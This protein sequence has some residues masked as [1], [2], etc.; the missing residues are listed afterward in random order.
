MKK[1]AYSIEKTKAWRINNEKC[2]YLIEVGQ[3]ISLM[4][5][6]GLVIRGTV[7]DC[8]TNHIEIV[9]N[10]IRDI[11]IEDVQDIQF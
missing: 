2:S 1:N 11:V 4:L 10:G 8:W 3:M 5:K 9:N 7:H 6:N